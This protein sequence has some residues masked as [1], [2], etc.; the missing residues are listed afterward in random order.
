MRLARF[1]ARVAKQTAARRSRTSGAGRRH[2]HS[3]IELAP[4][5]YDKASLDEKRGALKLVAK[6]L[7]ANVPANQGSQDAKLLIW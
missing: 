5:V 3:R 2:G 7:Q 4:E 1:P 6:D